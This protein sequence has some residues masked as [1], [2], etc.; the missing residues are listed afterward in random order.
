MHPRTR[1]T[2]EIKK[3]NNSISPSI[4]CIPPVSY[5]EMLV[6]E[7]NARVILT[8]SGGVQKEA[9]FSKVPCITLRDETEWDELVDCGCNF[10][11]GTDPERIISAYQTISSCEIEF[12]SQLYGDGKTSQKINRILFETFSNRYG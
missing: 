2:I 11:C 9:Y 8:D 6:L 10:V 7:R 3:L 12:P 5:L 4:K 1:K